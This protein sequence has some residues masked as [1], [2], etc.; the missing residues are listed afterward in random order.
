MTHGC[1]LSIA[2][3]APDFATTRQL[4]Q[5]G[6]GVL[7]P[8]VALDAL[9]AVMLEAWHRPSHASPVAIAKVDW[10]VIGNHLPRAGITHSVAGTV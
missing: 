2:G 7:P 6:L 5:T 3:S 4:Q 8:A 1:A 9:A 10:N